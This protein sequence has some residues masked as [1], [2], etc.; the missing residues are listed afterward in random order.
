MMK[1]TS[2]HI[3]RF[4]NDVK[5]ENGSSLSISNI[6]ERRLTEY[7]EQHLRRHNGAITRRT[8]D[9][10]KSSDRTSLEF[11]PLALSLYNFVRPSF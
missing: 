6:F 7:A 4:Q 2:K 10:G 3:E 1:I 9:F 11:P 8:T 5:G